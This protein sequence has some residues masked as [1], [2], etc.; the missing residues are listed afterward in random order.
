[1]RRFAGDLDRQAGAAKDPRH[2]EFRAW[3]VVQLDLVGLQAGKA[4]HLLK[5]ISRSRAL[6]LQEAGPAAA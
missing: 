5:R 4:G 2:R 1:M 6:C 3:T